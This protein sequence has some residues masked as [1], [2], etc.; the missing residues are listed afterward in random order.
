MGTLG[1]GGACHYTGSMDSLITFFYDRN[2]GIMGWD[3]G[4]PIEGPS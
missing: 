4:E 1:I 2:E 3:M